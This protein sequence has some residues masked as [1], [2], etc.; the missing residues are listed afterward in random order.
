MLR[1]GSSRTKMRRRAPPNLRRRIQGQRASRKSSLQHPQGG[2]AGRR[3]DGGGRAAAIGRRAGRKFG[4]ADPNGDLVE[5]K[6]EHFGDDLGQHRAD[7][8]SDIL[9]ARQNF[10]RTVAHD[11]N[12]AGT[13]GLHIGA[14]QR[15]RDSKT[16]LYRPGSAPGA[17]LRCQPIRS[18]PMRRS[19]RRT[20]LRSIRS[21]SRADRWRAVRPVRRLSV[22]EPRRPAYCR[23]RASR[24]RVRH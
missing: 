11:A 17:C 3:R 21:R 12:F 9:H 1:L 20:G 8:G 14:P 16:A 24:S 22:P 23:V 19:S 10:D 6:S 4:V 13:I 18:A 2:G 7:S 15:L 5:M